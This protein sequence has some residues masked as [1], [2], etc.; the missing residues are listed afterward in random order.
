MLGLQRLGKTPVL[1]NG[2]HVEIPAGTR[3][4]CYGS[5]VVLQ[6]DFECLVMEVLSDVLVLCVFYMGCLT[7]R[8]E[9]VIKVHW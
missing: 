8:S 7:V 2:D 9:D 5:C 4:W 1:Q 3:V 6:R